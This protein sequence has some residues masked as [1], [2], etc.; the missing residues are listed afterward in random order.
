MNRNCVYLLTV[1]HNSWNQMIYNQIYIQ[2]DIIR[3]I[4]SPV[5]MFSVKFQYIPTIYMV[6]I[7]IWKDICDSQLFD[8]IPRKIGERLENLPKDVEVL[9]DE[10]QEHINNANTQLETLFIQTMNFW[11]SEMCWRCSRKT[12]YYVSTLIFFFTKPF[13]LVFGNL[14]VSPSPHH[15]SAEVNMKG[16]KAF[17]F[18]SVN[19]DQFSHTIRKLNY[20]QLKSITGIL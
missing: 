5:A 8:R 19:Q 11:N 3:N 6:R 18:F 2:L 17:S 12:E 13:K 4:S 1:I 15:F 10:M 20:A 9:S 14:I 7:Y 16:D